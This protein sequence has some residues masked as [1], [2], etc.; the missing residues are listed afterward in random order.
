MA[1]RVD[2]ANSIEVDD[3]DTI[4]ITGGGY[5]NY[6]FK[7][8][9]RDS[10]MGWE[11]P[12]W[13]GDLTR[14]V[15]FVLSNIDDVDFGLVARCEIS[16]KYMN[17]QDYIALCKIAKQRVCTANFF[18]RETGERVTQ[19]M[20]FT[21]N[22]L[23]KL[24]AF[25]KDYLGTTDVSIKLVATNR[26]RV[27]IISGTHTIRYV[28]WIGYGDSYSQTAS[29]S[30]SL[31]LS[32]GE[33]FTYDPPF[34]FIGWN[35]KTDGSGYDYLPNQNITVF[36][37]LN[38]YAQWGWYNETQELKYNE[39]FEN[40]RIVGYSVASPALDESENIA[41][42]CIP[43]L[44]NR[45]PVKSIAPGAFKNNTSI[46]SITVEKKNNLTE[47]G[48]AGP[49]AGICENCTSLT[50]FSFG[51]D[52]QVKS[53]RPYSFSGCSA[54]ENVTLPG[55]LERIDTRAFV[56]CSSLQ[57]LRI[58]SLVFNYI[59]PFAFYNCSSLTTLYIYS[60]TPPELS[61]ASAISTATTT[62]YIRKGTLSQYLNSGIWFAFSH[63]LVEMEV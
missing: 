45:R 4:Y 16:Y 12:V 9:S 40:G 23:G 1:T 44:H 27:G 38:L 60:L 34:Y 42:I 35:T 32:S 19:E 49:Y 22:E 31:K 14:S 63:L 3:L 18:N 6:P 10:A 48:K 33:N 5:V 28:A 46:R 39:I 61:E 57:T 53:I 7:G 30:E 17:V 43:N 58:D 2:Y 51:S 20:A 41:D 36:E 55:Q 37:D 62:I 26:D 29:W 11:E 54:L 47:I 8:I 21:G 24:Y 13:G 52:S 50:S 56:N 25:G 59:G 15:D